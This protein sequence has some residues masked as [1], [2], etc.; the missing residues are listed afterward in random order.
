MY[1]KV[2][3]ASHAGLDGYVVQVEVDISVGIPM[4]EIVGLPTASVREARER[5][6][7]AILNSGFTFP[8]KRIV[9]NL[10]PADRKKGGSSLDLPIIMGILCASGQVKEEWVENTAFVGEMS[11]QGEILPIR[12]ILAMALAA[13]E[14][15][16]TSFYTACDNYK[17]AKSSDIQ[18]VK[19]FSTL[20]DCIRYLKE[21]IYEKPHEI[22]EADIQ[23]SY[24]MD[25]QDV[26]GQQLA[27]RAMEIAAAGGHNMMMVGPPGSGKTMLAQ[28]M[29][30]ILPPL[31]KEE[32]IEVTKI[33]SVAGLLDGKSMIYT[34][35]FR[36]PHHTITMASMVGGGRLPRPG[37]VTLSHCGVL[38][39]DE[40]PEFRREVLEVLRQPIEEDVVHVSR[41]QGSYTYPA[42]LSLIVAM[43][44]CPCGYYG[45]PEK[46]CRCTEREVTNYRRKISG[47][48][49]DR[50][51]LFLQLQR[52]SYDELQSKD[53]GESSAVI[54]KRV[55]AARKVQ[56]ER[57]RNEKMRM[58][59]KMG[60]RQVERYCILETEAERLLQ[61]AF[62]NLHMSARSFD[63]VKKVART[64]ADLAGED[65][66]SYQSMAEALSFRDAYESM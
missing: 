49:V 61:A 5:V 28:R 56:K 62:L 37:E 60:H 11:L 63:H 52:P 47:P 51:D 26:K 17:E 38:F 29:V 22:C 32:A 50:I 25:M 31:G 12:G 8:L 54:R 18:D 15:G 13:K 30:T 19:G 20:T 3:G 27:K 58:N 59:A 66:I 4:F 65:R 46:N 23:R 6:R 14:E 41:V 10:A 39:L 40:L 7:A 64:I 16:L 53:Y 33:Y 44:P 57:F 45:D 1:A 34:R 48:L 36:S 2:Y 9:V 43:N 42:N 35:P 24:A 55:V 21:G